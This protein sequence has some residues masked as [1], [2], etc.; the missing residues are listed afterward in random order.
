MS[1]FRRSL[2][3][4]AVVVAA[5]QSFQASAQTASPSKINSIV[6]KLSSDKFEGR[7][8][9][10]PGG[11]KTEEWL[12]KEFAGLKLEK[13][14]ALGGYGQSFAFTSK[15][16]LGEGNSLSIYSEGK[17]AAKLKAEDDFIPASFSEDCDIKG[18][19]LIFAGF[20]IKSRN[21]ERND[22]EGLDVKDKVV[23]VLRDGPEGDDPKSRWA[24]FHATRY[25]ATTARELGARALIVVSPTEKG[26]ELP[27]MRTGA[28]A[29]SASIPVVSMKLAF[30]K[31]LFEIE[32]A[33]FP[34]ED[35]MESAKS[36]LLTK[37]SVD[38]QVRLKRE[39]STASNIVGMLPATVKTAETI[40]I[41]A[42]WDH[43]GRGIEGSLAEK[44]G[45]IHRGADDN[46]SGTAGV[47]ELAR[48]L[49]KEKER[50]RNVVFVCF[51][52]E[53]LG[54]LGSVYFT[55]NPPVPLQDVIAMIN[56]DMIGRFKDK[57]VV[58]GAGTAKEWKEILEKANT[59]NLNL[60]LHEDG[61]GASDQ[62]A[63]Y[64]KLIP[65]LFFFSGAH[66]DYHLPSD[67]PEK[68]NYEG[69]AKI[70]KL[71]ANVVT[72]TM[73]MTGKPSYVA[74]E[75]NAGA[76]RASF[77]VYVG[78]VPDFTEEGKGFKVLS[79]R[80]GSPAEKA[81]IKGGDLLVSLGGKH[82]EN[83]YDYT[84]AL[85]EFKPDEEAEAV[86]IRDGREV[87]LKLIF[88]SRKVSE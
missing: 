17:E 31:K 3:F 67:T 36:F 20:G 27:G 25:K 88:G 26:D 1:H 63:F 41:G 60:S 35:G 80:P 32:G 64:A 42:H 59:E 10:S 28:A 44:F 86:V 53:E 7:L 24:P 12:K 6:A 37:S 9:G 4:V 84:Y 83:I 68:I 52:A 23:I 34:T 43:L 65:V 11:A 39:K 38:M 69:E 2:T 22:Y 5:I 15:V 81:G 58:D 57:V 16:S 74:T 18:A 66:G 77:K 47:L 75:G 87:K 54:G 49:S 76:G 21:P 29:G 50:K 8:A 70:L 55:K 48:T 82:I 61:Y 62:S 13:L 19:G 45:E 40:V 72:E 73:N 14:P 79:V 78:T 85:Q 51:A 71:V 30:L 33:K 56:L 46:G